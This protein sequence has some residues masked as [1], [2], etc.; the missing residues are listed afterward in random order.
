MN[1][2]HEQPSA[3]TSSIKQTAK[4]LVISPWVY[5][6][7]L[8]YTK[9]S[10]PMDVPEAKALLPSSGRAVVGRFASLNPANPTTEQHSH[11]RP[12]STE[13]TPSLGVLCPATH[14]FIFP[15]PPLKSITSSDIPLLQKVTNNS[16]RWDSGHPKASHGG[17]VSRQWFLFVAPRSEPLVLKVDGGRSQKPAQALAGSWQLTFLPRHTHTWVYSTCYR[18]LFWLLFPL[19]SPS[20]TSIK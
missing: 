19:E 1:N 14:T 13:G 16:F 17:C 15:G 20:V 9:T 11:A 5:L 18:W 10:V 8:F 12:S 3:S 7:L 6:S 4:G 2:R